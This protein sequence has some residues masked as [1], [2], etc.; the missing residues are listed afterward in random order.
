MQDRRLLTLDWEEI[1]SRA[2]TYAR[3][4]AAF[5]AASQL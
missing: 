5:A 2:R 3:D 4:L 1:A